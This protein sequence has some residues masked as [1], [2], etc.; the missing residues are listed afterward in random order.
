M[1]TTTFEATEAVVAEAKEAVE[2][3][4]KVFFY[5]LDLPASH[6]PILFAAACIEAIESV[7]EWRLDAMDVDGQ[8]LYL[9]FRR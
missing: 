6:S 3:D 1:P 4:R 7:K 9:L 5:G 2:Q 8:T